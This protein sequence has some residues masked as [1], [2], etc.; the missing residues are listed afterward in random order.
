VRGYVGDDE[1]VARYAPE[2]KELPYLGPVGA[3]GDALRL[4]VRSAP[5]CATARLVRSPP[6]RAAE[7]PGDHAARARARRDPREP[8]RR[9]LHGRVAGDP[10]LALAV[11]G[12]P[13]RVSYLLFD[14]RI[15]NAVAAHDPFFARV[16]LRGRRDARARSAC[17]R[18]QLELPEAALRETIDGYTRGLAEPYYGV[19]R[20]RRAAGDA[21]RS[22][23]R[24]RG[25]RS[26]RVGQRDRGCSRSAARR[27]ACRGRASIASSTESTR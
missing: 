13:G 12:Q 24:R 23:R 16:V 10:S 21:R 6:S 1:L 4:A 11:R 3:K 25:A 7:P 27:R 14:E 5:P 20:H 9:P 17:S 8:A 26:R 22:G 15:A 19:A 2:L 18:K